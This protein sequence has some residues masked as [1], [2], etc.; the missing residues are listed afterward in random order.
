MGGI[1]DIFSN[2]TENNSNVVSAAG[3]NI[4]IFNYENNLSKEINQKNDFNNYTIEDNFEKKI[5]IEKK[6]IEKKTFKGL[7][8]LENIK[9][10][11]IIKEIIIIKGKNI[12]IEQVEFII[13]KIMEILYKDDDYEGNYTTEDEILGD[14]N[15]KIGF[16]DA[17]IENVRKI[18][19][20]GKNPTEKE[21]ED[22]LNNL[23]S[24]YE[25]T[26]LLACEILDD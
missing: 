5:S 23:N 2:Q 19:F 3:N 7:T 22:A 25:N 10:F 13:D 21:V 24:G 6:F 8:I 18:I 15:I 4:N 11:L 26:Q 17:N 16:Y 14:L 9:Q 20:N 12:T 1:G